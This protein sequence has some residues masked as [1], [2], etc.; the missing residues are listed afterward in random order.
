MLEALGL[1]ISGVPGRKTL[2]WISA[3]SGVALFTVD[4]RGL[5][6][7]AGVPCGRSFFY[8]NDFSQGRRRAKADLSGGLEVIVGERLPGGKVPFLQDAMR[9]QLTSEQL[10]RVRADSILYRFVRKPRSHAL[11]IRVLV[12]DTGTGQYETVHVPVSEVG[13]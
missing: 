11:A 4:A 9:T 1:H 7:M 10:H 6:S 5:I 12:R 3:Q 13:G 8:S 2:M